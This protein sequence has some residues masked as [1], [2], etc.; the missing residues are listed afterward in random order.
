MYIGIRL[1]H[2]TQCKE[3][4]YIASSIYTGNKYAYTIALLGTTVGIEVGDG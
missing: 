1:D 4:T 3:A 2:I